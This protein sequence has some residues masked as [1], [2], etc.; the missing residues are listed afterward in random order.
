MPRN[1]LWQDCRKSA[2][3]PSL[4]RWVAR[5]VTLDT[6]CVVNSFFLGFENMHCGCKSLN[7]RQYK[8]FIRLHG[9]NT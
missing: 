7:D 3:I 1:L 4:K 6:F 5:H 9:S 8:G 2:K